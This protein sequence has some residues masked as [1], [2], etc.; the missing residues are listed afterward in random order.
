M[1][2]GVSGRSADGRGRV[3]AHGMAQGFLMTRGGPVPVRRDNGYVSEFG[4]GFGEERDP[5][6]CDP[7]VVGNDDFEWIFH[8]EFLSVSC[9][10]PGSISDRDVSQA[11]IKISAP[12]AN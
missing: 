4:S 9:G 7:V 6:R 2:A 5:G 8:K 10:R 12:P 1:V 3:D 11:A